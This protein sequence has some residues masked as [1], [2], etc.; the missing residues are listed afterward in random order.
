MVRLLLIQPNY[1]LVYSY[2]G[3]DTATPIYPPLGLAYIAAVVREAGHDVKI[4]ESN[5]HNLTHEQ[6]KKEI[7][8]YNPDFIALSASSS[9]MNEVDKLSNLCPENVKVILGGIHASSAPDEVLTNHP[10]ID[11]VVRREGEETIVEILENKPY[12]QIDGISYRDNNGNNIHNKDSKFIEDLDSLP[13]PARDLLPMDKYFSFEARRSP[14]DYI[15]SGR[16]CPYRCTFCAD[17]ITSGRKLRIRSGESIVKEIQFLVDKYSTQEIDFQDDNFTFYPDRIKEFCDLMIKTGLNKKIVW[18]VANG[19]RC[20]KLTLPMLKHMKKAGCYMLSLGIE[21]GNQEILDK[22][23]KAEKLEDIRNAANWCHQVGIESR[24]LFI[25]GNIGENRQTMRD[26][27]EFAKSL[28]LDTA[29]FHICI[30]MPS[31]EHH[32]IIKKEGKFLDVGFEGLTAYSDGAFILGDVNPKLMSEMQKKAYKQFYI[33]P[34][35]V[36]KRFLRI[37]SLDD[38]KLIAKGGLE[39]LKFA[40]N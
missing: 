33:R 7:F 35:F 31:T 40:T 11:L 38:I 34:S 14:I 22:M 1:R 36:M 13:F 18:K 21:S 29:T 19:V 15:V 17:F 8:N 25:F 16:G 23:R 10:K 4:L 3:S 32:E 27:I 2:A 12:E 30:P 28:P 26:T 9:L 5:A 37:R 39:V 24:G 6:I 20:D